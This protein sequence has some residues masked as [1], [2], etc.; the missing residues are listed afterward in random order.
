[1]RVTHLPKIKELARGKARM[2]TQANRKIQSQRHPVC[3]TEVPR[4]P[5]DVPLG[6]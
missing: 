3:C 2:R 4:L 6:A 1:M 5:L